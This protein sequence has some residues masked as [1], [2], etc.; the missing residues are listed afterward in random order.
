MFILGKK[1]CLQSIACRR[2]ILKLKRRVNT[3]RLLGWF[4]FSFSHGMFIASIFCIFQSEG[5]LIQKLFVHFHCKCL[6]VLQVELACRHRSL[7]HSI[8]LNYQH[9]K[10]QL[11]CDSTLAHDK[12]ALKHAGVPLEQRLLQPFFFFDKIKKILPTPLVACA[13]AKLFVLQQV[14]LVV[15][16]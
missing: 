14:F 12:R 13:S 11:A 16:A 6:S 9:S 2:S 1:S 3:A 7:L 4:A 8:A 5:S 10:L 15:Q